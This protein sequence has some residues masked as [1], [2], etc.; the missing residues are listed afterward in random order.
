MIRAKELKRKNRL[1]VKR[2][3]RVSAKIRGTK[4]TPRIVVHKSNK[5][6]YIQAID[7]DTGVTICALHSK[8]KDIKVNKDGAKVLAV[9]FATILKDKNIE[10]AK[11]DKSGYRYHGVIASFVDGI[12][13][14]G[15]K[16]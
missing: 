9:D 13:E 2:K 8:K 4:E 1:F 14:N 16:I 3:L 7:D 10:V 5:Y 11:F 6:F 15:I 12:R